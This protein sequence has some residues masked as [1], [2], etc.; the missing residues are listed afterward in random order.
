M[1]SFSERTNIDRQTI[2]ATNQKIHN[3]FENLIN[4]EF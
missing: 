3:E 4:K 1:N 2:I